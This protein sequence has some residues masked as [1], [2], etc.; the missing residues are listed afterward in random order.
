MQHYP[1]VRKAIGA[2][3]KIFEYID[4]SPKMPPDGHLEPQE[5]RGHIQFKNVSFSYSGKTDSN[6][7]VL[8]V[9]PPWLHCFL[10]VIFLKTLQ[11]ESSQAFSFSC[12]DVS[13]EL[14]PGKITAVVGRNSSGK[15]TCVR[16]LD[17][18]YQPQSGTILLDGEPLTKY[19]DRYLHDKVA[20]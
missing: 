5:L 13:F 19:K 7:P 3:E 11:C 10:C 12:K 2:A 1:S 18:F 6:S 9:C 17:R 14:K 15:S 8:K 20:C 4:R 16:L